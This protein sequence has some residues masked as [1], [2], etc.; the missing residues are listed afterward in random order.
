[1]VVVQP[2]KFHIEMDINMHVD[3]S[4]GK[5]QMRMALQTKL[6][7]PCTTCISTKVGAVQARVLDPGL[8]A[9]GFTGLT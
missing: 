1:M 7:Y 3:D 8:K 2:K 9:P 6:T 4:D 5:G